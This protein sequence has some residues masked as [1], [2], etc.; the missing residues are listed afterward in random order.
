MP[1]FATLTAALGVL[2]AVWTIVGV[3]LG[4]LAHRACFGDTSCVS[5]SSGWVVQSLAVALLVVSGLCFVGPKSL[6]YLSA[7]FSAV[8]AGSV[9]AF[10]DMTTFAELTLVLFAVTVALSVYAAR[11]QIPVSEQGHPMNLPVFG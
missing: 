3:F 1:R 10:T 5:T 8:I 7:L 6:F 9:Y 4:Y 11:R 2:T